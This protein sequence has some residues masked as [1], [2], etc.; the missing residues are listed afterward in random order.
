R[1][2]ETYRFTVTR[3]IATVS[4]KPRKREPKR[5][6]PF[7]LQSEFPIHFSA[8]PS[9][10]MVKSGDDGASL[11]ITPFLKKCYDMVD[12]DSTNSVISWSPN[13]DSFIIWDMTEFSVTLLPAYFKHSNTASFV[14]QL[15][16]YGFRKVDPDRWEFANDGFIKGKKHLLKNITRRKNPQEVEKVDLWKEIENLKID[17]NAVTQELVKLRQHQ[18]TADE[19]LLLLRDRLKGMETNQQ[20]ML[21]FLVMVMQHPGFVVQLL[22]PKENSWRMAEPGVIIEQDADDNEPSVSDGSIVRYQPQKEHKVSERAHEPSVDM[23]Q[24][25]DSNL[26]WDW[27]KDF[28]ISSDFMKMLSEE[29]PSA[30]NNS[31][32]IIPELHD[33]SSWEQILRST[34]SLVDNHGGDGDREDTDDDQV[35]TGRTLPSTLMTADLFEEQMRELATFEEVPH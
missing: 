34:T 6:D 30:G 4:Q 9:L 13:S 20:Q 11:S 10:A 3:R 28:S 2:T 19:K 27:M 7:L 35:E 1:L 12:D 31:P 14:R 17:K 32:F 33:D 16:I 23:R 25:D 15:N 24:Q 22:H 5:N 21:S 29:N 8:F 18:E 26:A